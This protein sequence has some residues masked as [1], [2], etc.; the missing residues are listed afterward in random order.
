MRLVCLPFR[1]FPRRGGALRPCASRPPLGKL[2]QRVERGRF[3]VAIESFFARRKKKKISC[4]RKKKAKKAGSGTT[5]CSSRPSLLLARASASRDRASESPS[6]RCGSAR[7]I[8]HEGIGAGFHQSLGCGE[9]GEGREASSIFQ[10]QG[11]PR[12]TKQQPQREREPFFSGWRILLAHRSGLA[13]ARTA[14]APL[15]AVGT[16]TRVDWARVDCIASKRWGGSGGG[17]GMRSALKLRER[18]SGERVK[19]R[20]KSRAKKKKKNENFSSPPKPFLQL[21]LDFFL[22][23]LLLSAFKRKWSQR[24]KRAL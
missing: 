24:T 7:F 17:E 8:L 4:G 1:P 10:A 18:K 6:R 9:G 11:A 13:A 22:L 3:P 21:T 15:R 2:S 12:K 20:E 5:T 14:T 16:A 19:S 23:F